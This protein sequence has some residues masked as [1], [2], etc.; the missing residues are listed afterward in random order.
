MNRSPDSMDDSFLKNLLPVKLT[1]SFRTQEQTEGTVSPPSG[2]TFTADDKLIVSDDFNHRIQIYDADRNLA[3]SF[4]SKGKNAGEFHYPK[5]TAVDP[6]GN[7]YVADSW[8][9]RIQKFDSNGNHLLS[10]GSCGEA[11]GQLNEPYDLHIAV[12]GEIIVVERY[13]HRIQFFRPD[14]SS[15]GWVG[16]RGTVLEDQ[17]AFI[18][19]TP[20]NLFSPPVFEFPTSIA[21]D[22]FGNFYI[23]D[24]GN[25]RIVKFDSEWKQILAFGERGEAPGQFQYPLCVC[26]GAN[27]FIY[28]TDLNNDRIQVFNSFGQFLFAF[29]ESTSGIPFKTPNLVTTDT[30]GRLHAG[31]TFNTAILSYEV[32]REPQTSL[33]DQLARNNPGS[34]EHAFFQAQIHAQAE[35]FE[36]ALQAC[37]RGAE[38]L[39]LKE[40]NDFET[41]DSGID[42]FLGM[43]RLVLK[44]GNTGEHESAL[45]KG[46]E[47]CLQRRQDARN[48]LMNAHQQWEE[49]ALVFGR[50]SLEQQ[51]AVL[52]QQEDPRVFNQELFEV[53]RLEKNLYRLYRRAVF[54][55]RKTV[56]LSAEYF[57]NVLRSE[58]A[59]TAREACI[60]A[61]AGRFHEHTAL[62]TRLLDEKE[63]HEEAMV[64]A[65]S[66]E[67]EE[68]KKWSAFLIRHFSTR[69]AMD[70]TQN[71]EYELRTLLNS[72]S[73]IAT[74]FPGD[75]AVGRS[76]H[77]LFLVAPTA[78]VIPKL[79]LGFHENW[80]VH[81]G[82]STS[83]KGLLDSLSANWSS[84]SPQ[85]R[86]ARLDDF[87]PVAYDAEDLN[88]SNILQ[89]LLVE[90]SEIT[91][92]IVCGNT[93][94]DLGKFDATA[95]ALATR[96][97]ETLANH[98][99]YDEKSRELFQQ[100]AALASQK[101][102]WERKL[103]QVN[104]QDKTQPI[105]IHNNI[106]L[107]DFQVLLVRRMI[108]TLDL[109]EANNITRLIIGA[110]C[111]ADL[112]QG[113]SDAQ[114]LYEA[115]DAFRCQLKK[116]INQAL[117]SRKT[118]F[119]Q[120]AH[121]NSR[122][123][124][125]GLGRNVESI[126]ESSQIA[127][128]ISAL[129]QGTEQLEF[130]LSRW[131]KNANLIDRFFDFL[132]GQGVWKRE[133]HARCLRPHLQIS[134][135]VI[136][137]DMGSR[138]H[139]YGL[140][141]TKEGEL[142]VAGY[143]NHKVFRFSPEGVCLS[144]FGGW[145]NHGGAMKYP[146]T[147]RIDS[148]GFIYVLDEKNKR[149]LQFSPL[150]KFVLA[151]GNEGEQRLGTAFC[152]SI[153]AQ[154]RIWVADPDHDRIQIYRQDGTPDTAITSPGNGPENLHQPVSVHCL[155]NGEYLVGDRS[156]YA[157]KRFDAGGKLLHAFKNCEAAPDDLYFLTADPVH[158]IFASDFW[159][160]QFVHL[161]QDLKLTAVYKIPGKRAGEWGKVAGLSVYKGTLAVSD[162][163]NFRVQV[164]KLPLPPGGGR[165]D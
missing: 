111:L 106:A 129:Q 41:P 1:G 144:H 137:S 110:A 131:C 108:C 151:F 66:E 12:S 147:T 8:N 164:F 113:T 146:V 101:Q 74:L 107:V 6:Q 44:V 38:T 19:E 18:Y 64:V 128:Q 57:L 104:P 134:L 145:G 102:E 70:V 25:H 124:D 40:S 84:P 143:E 56:Q 115:I 37:H 155:E 22:S 42:S 162:F 93:L 88:L 120:T 61:L 165:P 52:Y 46:I 58:L 154:D 123:Q 76:L 141:H 54:S 55:Y 7:I 139:P 91:A 133:A 60:K 65:L 29:N 62:M 2:L 71:L 142:L 83:L 36:S 103:K 39:W 118:G 135:G 9:H 127:S 109:N 96:L 20:L 98:A 10:F 49:Q 11:P 3:H 15:A 82:M 160:N 85:R 5:G 156:E 94:Y 48:R 63:K 116:E 78:E 150:E 73:S 26:S 72:F 117:Q 32:S 100:L 4:G 112:P 130:R 161:S 50:K 53:E 86:E 13:N 95:A 47:F 24:S 125:L 99:S 79:L 68:E 34:Y 43:S 28:V 132:R 87:A 163:D 77:D 67:Q 157:L 140:T 17:L 23:S 27:D 75:P 59:E 121:L 97:H 21:K 45:M 126:E 148:R 158:G 114:K 136:G 153:D 80:T 31:L 122:L 159:N 14:G 152:I 138:L 81:E 92:G 69:R 89:S 30:Q 51:K 90:G 35:D 105:V 119:I 16:T 149:V 33:A